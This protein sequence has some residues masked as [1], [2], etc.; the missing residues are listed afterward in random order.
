MSFSALAWAAA[1]RP[2]R[3]S[4]KL[5]LLALADRHN[6]EDD[7]AYPSVAWLSDFTGLNRKTVITSISRLEA[8]GY[9]ADA[10]VRV[11]ATMQVKAYRLCFEKQDKPK[12]GTVP[13]FPK[14]PVSSGERSQK[15]DTEPVKEPT[16]ESKDSSDSTPRNPE[17]LDLGLPPLPPV[18]PTVDDLAI[19]I[20]EEW[21]AR[22]F[23]TPLRGQMPTPAAA[24][25]AMKLAKAYVVG[26]QSVIDVWNELFRNIDQSDFLQGKVAGRDGRPPFKLT[27]SFLLEKRNFEKTLEGRFGGQSTGE[28]RRGST[29]EATGRFLNRI[30]SGQGRSTGGRD[31]QRA[32]ARR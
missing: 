18:D 32:L 25:K 16:S 19:R 17:E 26:D 22:A 29:S 8:A 10:G 2:S 3:S 13:F 24:E 23:A 12:K 5:L 27:L 14:S 20:S 21:G 7:M 9:I 30:R 11:G 28:Q 6:S 31:S 1:Q 15:R 4:E